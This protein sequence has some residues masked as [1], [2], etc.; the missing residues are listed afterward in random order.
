MQ[1]DQLLGSPCTWVEITSAVNGTAT[2]THAA[3]PGWTYYIGG[4]SVSCSAQPT[5]P[6]TVL[7]QD[8]A[9]LLDQWE[10]PAAAFGPIIPPFFRPY[11]GTRGNAVSV[12]V[13]AMGAGVRGTVSIRGFSGYDA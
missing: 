4:I 6:V 9:T 13:G 5:G 2:A 3:A 7:I 12:S 1:Q 11:R 8:G 10:I